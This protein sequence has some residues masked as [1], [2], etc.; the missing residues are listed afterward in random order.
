MIAA[1]DNNMGIGINNQLL[2]YLS[3][4]L[5]HFK[6]T[7][8]G[9]AIIMGR[10]TFDSLPNRKPLPGRENIILTQ[11]DENLFPS[12]VT[13]VHNLQEA[14]KIVD[15]TSSP[16]FVIGGAT[17]YQLFLPYTN[18]LYLTE[19]HATWHADSFFPHIDEN[20]WQEKEKETHHDEKLNINYSFTVWVRKSV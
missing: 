17:I 19:L 15:A 5:K 12:D 7:T 14:L 16:L 10:K 2:C 3:A 13:I 9:H 18:T 20:N 4:D 6:A 1:V 8:M 11:Q